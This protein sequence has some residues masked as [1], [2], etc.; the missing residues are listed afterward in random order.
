MK[1]EV[2]MNLIVSSLHVF[3]DH[4]TKHTT[5]VRMSMDCLDLSASLPVVLHDDGLRE[6]RRMIFPN[7]P[8]PSRTVLYSW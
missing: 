3:L 7:G 2:E 5:C 4:H 1:I 6:Q 8:C